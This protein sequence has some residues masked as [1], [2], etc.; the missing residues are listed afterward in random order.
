MR[1]FFSPPGGVDGASDT[2]R[3]MPRL[4][5]GR[6]GEVDD[7]GGAFAFSVAARRQVAA[8][9]A[10]EL[11]RYVQAQSRAMRDALGGV[12]L[13]RLEQPQRVLRLEAEAVVTHLDAKPAAVDTRRELH[14]AAAILAR[15]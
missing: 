3:L 11:A 6:H 13:E 12:A 9:A 10:H 8:H 14:L 7:E 1:G 4:R 5:G 15:V 2:N